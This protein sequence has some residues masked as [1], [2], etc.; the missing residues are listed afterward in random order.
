MLGRSACSLLGCFGE[1]EENASSTGGGRTALHS[2]R[3]APVDFEKVD[4]VLSHLRIGTRERLLESAHLARVHR[5]P[6]VNHSAS[7]KDPLHSCP[8]RVHPPPRQQAFLVFSSHAGKG[9]HIAKECAVMTEMAPAAWSFSTHP[10]SSWLTQS[11]TPQAKLPST[12]ITVTHVDIRSFSATGLWHGSNS[13]EI[14]QRRIPSLVRASLTTRAEALG[15][16]PVC[17][18]HL[19]TLVR[20]KLCATHTHVRYVRGCLAAR[21]TGDGPV[22]RTLSAATNLGVEEVLVILGHELAAL[23]AKLHHLRSGQSK[24]RD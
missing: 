15:L 23:V 4:E 20:S 5:L 24:R 17:L 6:Q 9:R 7:R 2:C 18:F 16:L 11:V 1:T 8:V 13:L 10:R 21:A 12:R 14:L 19:G 3:F 22:N